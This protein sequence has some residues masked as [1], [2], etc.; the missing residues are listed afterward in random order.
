[1][2]QLQYLSFHNPINPLLFFAIATAFIALTWKLSS[3]LRHRLIKSSFYLVYGLS[4]AIL[5]LL[6]FMITQP[7]LHQSHVQKNNPRLLVLFDASSST[8]LR[9][10]APWK[11]AFQKD[12]PILQ[13]CGGYKPEYYLFSEKIIKL[14]TSD[15]ALPQM[16]EGTFIGRSIETLLK[17]LAPGDT[18]RILLFSDGRETFSGQTQDFFRLNKI[19]I[20]SVGLGENSEASTVPEDLILD[21]LYVNDLLPAHEECSIRGRIRVQG[22]AFKDRILINLYANQKLIQKNTLPVSKGKNIY[23]TEFLWKPTDKEDVTL[24]MEI[25][26]QTDEKNISNNALQKNVR[27]VIHSNRILFM[28]F[29]PDWESKMILQYLHSL[30]NFKTDFLLCLGENIWK[31]SSPE[32]KNAL[33][34]P[35]ILSRYSLIF[36]SHLPPLKNP[37]PFYSS[38][39]QWIS[40]LGGTLILHPGNDLFN[41]Q[42]PLPSSLLKLLPV[43][44]PSVPS[45]MEEIVNTRIS[46]DNSVKLQNISLPVEGFL[47]PGK[48]K[49]TAKTILSSVAGDSSVPLV[50]SQKY[51]LGN[52]IFLSFSSSWKWKQNSSAQTQSLFPM[53]WDSILSDNLNLSP[54]DGKSRLAIETELNLYSLNEMIPFKITLPPEVKENEIRISCRSP[55]GKDFLIP[56][57][58]LFR[59]GNFLLSSFLA[60]EEGTYILQVSLRHNE[61]SETQTLSI[62]TRKNNTEYD[63]LTLNRFYLKKLSQITG[64]RYISWNDYLKTPLVWKAPEA[65]YKTETQ[66]GLWN[67]P[68]IVSLLVF[69]FSLLWIFKRS[70]RLE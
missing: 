13:N 63:D 10:D 8:H 41:P 47:D 33:P 12:N 58:N 6:L 52:S 49:N 1:M 46:G 43:I 14:N 19:P 15:I 29:S 21:A 7:Y 61:L 2:T 27:V 11:L 16:P 40:N 56:G 30:K 18:P 64:G 70:I 59:E 44:P 55:S 57:G 25:E 17:T 53:F 24:K 62:N 28:S 68:L 5:L 26:P 22:A 69:L 42:N 36:L 65:T 3:G 54:R 38:L 9:G 32:F 31:T 50:C 66:T 4:N 51:G 23:E 34:S 60:E 67:H 45:F 37:E 20:D 35:E 48:L 39:L